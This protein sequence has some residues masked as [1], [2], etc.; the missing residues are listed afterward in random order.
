[1]T[2]NKPCC[3]CEPAVRKISSTWNYKNYCGAILCRISD[4]FRSKHRVDPGLYTLGSPTKESPV[5]VTANYKLTFDIVRKDLAAFDAWLLVLDTKG[6]NVWCAAGKGSFGTKELVKRIESEKLI[7]KVT[8]RTII[9][10]QLGAPGVRAHEVKKITGFSVCFGP[11]RSEDIKEFIA[12]SNKAT[13]SMR[14]VTFSTA[15]RMVLAPL[16]VI[17]S[18]KKLWLPLFICA[19]IMGLSREGI[20]F[21][22]MWTLTCPFF[23]ALCTAII[24]GALIHPLILPVMPFRSFAIQGLILGLL[25]AVIVYFSHTVL[26]SSAYGNIAWFTLIATVS[27][28]IAFNFTGST[29]IANKSGVKKELRISFPLY[30]AA[31]AA[32]IVLLVLYKLNSE[33]ML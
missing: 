28:Y 25:S 6:I 11:V 21:G 17:A 14:T 4:R 13:P 29:P 23:I 7:E 8:H 12:Q 18:V 10:P 5:L 31:T 22:K 3:C 20:L 32:T 27:S 15:E 1:M 9:V 24:A 30:I 2:E 26:I 33:G 16:E 19:L